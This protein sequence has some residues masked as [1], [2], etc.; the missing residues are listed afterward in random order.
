MNEALKT[1]DALPDLLPCPFCGGE[2]VEGNDY[3]MSLIYV[4]CWTCRTS[5]RYYEKKDR[6]L[7]FAAWNRR[8][9]LERAYSAMRK[10][11]GQGT[12]NDTLKT[13]DALPEGI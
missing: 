1:I 4:Y 13:R 6:A 11:Q 9:S 12:L 3:S 10:A 8:L 2:A 5:S 7:M